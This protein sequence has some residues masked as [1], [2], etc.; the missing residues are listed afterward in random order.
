MPILLCMLCLSDLDTDAD[1]NMMTK[2]QN[3]QQTQSTNKQ[4]QTNHNS[5][6]HC[7]V[8]CT[9]LT[10]CQRTDDLSKD[11]NIINEDNNN[12]LYNYDY[13]INN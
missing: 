11:N 7:W 8:N 13:F 1:V 2:Q 10:W 5:K 3:N 6:C 4:Q 9:C 12:K